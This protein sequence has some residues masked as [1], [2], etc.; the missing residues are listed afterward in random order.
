M[1]NYKIG[2][3]LLLSRGVSAATESKIGTVIM[4]DYDD[5]S[6]LRHK[7]RYNEHK[8]GILWIYDDEILGKHIDV[9]KILKETLWPKK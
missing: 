2:D 9:L 8:T 5:S 6:G 1:K 3:V 4:T 7:I